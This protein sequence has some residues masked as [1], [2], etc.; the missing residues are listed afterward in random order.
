MDDAAEEILP[1]PVELLAVHDVSARLFD[2][3][4]S[5]FDVEARV[6]IDLTDVDS[7]VTEALEQLR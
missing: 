6:G 1:K 4:R 3:L 5:W 7:A 2:T